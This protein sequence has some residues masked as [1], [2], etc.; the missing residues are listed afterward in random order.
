MM[1]L[2]LGLGYKTLQGNIEIRSQTAPTACRQLTNAPENLFPLQP[3][4]L[5][6]SQEQVA[7]LLAC[8]GILL[9]FCPADAYSVS[10]SLSQTTKAVHWG[11]A[12]NYNIPVLGEQSSSC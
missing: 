9:L 11:K 4:E 3:T 5:A 12:T 1:P 8:W 2:S 10:G 7:G 6:F